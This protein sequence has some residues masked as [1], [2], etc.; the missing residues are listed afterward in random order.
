MLTILHT[1]SS[2]GWG[3]QEIRIVQESA[4]M[5]ARGYR[6]II[7]APERSKIFRRA[8]EEGLEVSAT[9]FSKKNPLTVFG[10]MLLI[11]RIRPDIINTHSSSDSW[12][13][14]IAAKLSRKKP[15]IIRTRHLSTP[16]SRAFT[17]RLIYDLLPDAVMTTGEEIR[18]GMIQVNG[19]NSSRIYSIPTGIDLSRYD[20]EKVK[21]AF[22]KGHFSVGMVGVLRSWKGH[23]YLLQAIPAVVNRIPK[24]HFYIVGDGPQRGNIERIIKDMSLQ[25]KISLLGHREDIPEIMAALDVIV[26]PSYAGEGIP[27]SLLQALAMKKP[28]VASDAGAIKEIIKDHITGFLIE[29]KNPGLISEKIVEIYNSRDLGRKFGE[30]GRKMVL[31]SH[32]IDIMLDMI[33]ALYRELS[34]NA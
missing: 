20:P 1:E 30:N 33:E 29:P 15:K 31:Q 23:V 5:S 9:E 24:A 32:S 10:A 34:E 4:G 27:Q 8:R 28:V 18:R 13:A 6:V 3:G 22:S 16:I 21:P 26:H 2:M 25:D 11:D 17:S 12:V 19:F 7:A 14:T